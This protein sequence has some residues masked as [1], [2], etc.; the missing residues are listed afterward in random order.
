MDTLWQVLNKEPAPVHQLNPAVPR[1]LETIC[2]KCL[3]KD[4]RRRYRTAEELAD[5]LRR[6]LRHEV[7]SAPAGSRLSD[8]R[9][10]R[11]LRPGE[12]ATGGCQ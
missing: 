9:V 7:G 6:F 10:Y 3:E 5:D 12:L 2:L 1:D 4:G 8:C 11:R